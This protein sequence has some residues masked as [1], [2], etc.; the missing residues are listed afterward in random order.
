M[1]PA[2]GEGTEGVTWS[3]RLIAGLGLLGLFVVWLI[4]LIPGSIWLLIH[5]LFQPK[6][7]PFG[8]TTIRSGQ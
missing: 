4:F 8:Q 7:E 1:T 5:L 2:Q 3:D 6:P